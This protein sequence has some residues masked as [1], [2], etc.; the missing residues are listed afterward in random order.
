MKRLKE[1]ADAVD[2]YRLIRRGL[3]EG[4]NPRNVELMVGTD[5]GDTTVYG[6][7]VRTICKRAKIPERK[8]YQ[9]S[10]DEWHQIAGF[11]AKNIDPMGAEFPWYPD[12]WK[13]S[14]AKFPVKYIQALPPAAEAI[15]A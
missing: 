4:S 1:L 9:Y 3:V 7:V 12:D 6:N 2:A 11:V 14:R 13:A 15:E 5:R 10:P 8:L